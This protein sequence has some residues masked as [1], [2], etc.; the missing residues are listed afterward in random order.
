MTVEAYIVDEL[1]KY[2]VTDI[3]GIPGGVILKLLYAINDRKSVLSPHLNFH[4]QMA[5]F[6]ALG[7]A[8]ACGKLGVAYATRGP[9]I[10]NMITC[11]AEAYQ[12]S[13]PVLFITAHGQRSENTMRFMYNQELNVVQS[14]AGFTKYAS[15]IETLNDVNTEF[16]KA[17]EYALEGRK[18]PVLLDFASD[19]FGQ[20]I[21]GNIDLPDN[22]LI[23]RIP[24]DHSTHAVN[25][26]FHALQH[27]QRPVILIGDGLREC[28]DTAYQKILEKL[29]CPVL[30]SRASQDLMS[31]S[32]LYY[33]YIG[34]HGLRYSNFILS[35]ADL[36]IS[37]GNRMSFP[38]DSIS[39][40]PVIEHAD[41]IRID[42]DENEFAH[43]LPSCFNYKADVKNFIKKL[44]NKAAFTKRNEDWVIICNYLKK[45]LNS[46]DITEPVRKL[47]K[48]LEQISSEY[49]YV[50]DVG[51]NEF[52]F[53]RAYEKTHPKGHVLYSKSFGT[54]GSSLGKAIGSYYATQKNILCI[55]GD[56]GFQYNLQE[57]Q[58]ISYWN[59]PIGIILLNN[60]ASGMI[61]DHERRLHSNNF[62]HVTP[63]TGYSIPDFKSLAHT[64]KID[65]VESIQDLTQKLNSQNKI[66]PFLYE[67]KYDYSISLIPNLPKGNTC[68]NMYPLLD[69][70][71]YDF[72]DQM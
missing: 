42:I 69:H 9:G 11:I 38:I 16:K 4:E 39:F 65:Y 36:V 44:E 46:Y 45:S 22:M 54:L 26:I 55:V 29:G 60:A 14:V 63:E 71:L 6:A 34:S 12:E 50:C 25:K 70:N 8:Q 48:L 67:I 2:G 15:N 64:Y 53:S 43:D 21:I 51:N 18:G 52:W 33:G 37:I 61:F 23:N 28:R 58:Y 56:Q 19:L 5:G 17:C 7:Y 10:T 72:L 41:I 40:K 3:F 49:I 31:Q 32:K 27:A 68:Q 24:N 62:I 13:L 20:N 35:K 57:L 30:S 1:I 59:I 66:T 47:V